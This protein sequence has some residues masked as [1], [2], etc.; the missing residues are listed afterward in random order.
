MRDMVRGWLC[1]KPDPSSIPLVVRERS[2]EAADVILPDS[3]PELEVAGR[4][5]GG[6]EAVRR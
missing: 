4:R 1:L 3:N 2:K 6:H 5:A